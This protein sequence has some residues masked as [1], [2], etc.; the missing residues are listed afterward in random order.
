MARLHWIDKLLK[1]DV[2]HDDFNEE[3]NSLKAAFNLVNKLLI[4]PN[5]SNSSY[6]DLYK[7]KSFNKE[8]FKF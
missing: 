7:L 2:L 8:A 4:F 3:E 1:A 5:S 6:S